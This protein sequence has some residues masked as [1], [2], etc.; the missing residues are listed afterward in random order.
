MPTS[1]SLAIALR[2][3]YV[4][5]TSRERTAP[6]IWSGVSLEPPSSGNGSPQRGQLA[7]LALSESDTQR[8]QL[9][10]TTRAGSSGPP[11]EPF[12]HP[13]RSLW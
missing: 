4:Y 5:P 8:Q 9:E 2:S 7:A 1:F 3:L 6:E 12:G 10:Q 11:D 13:D